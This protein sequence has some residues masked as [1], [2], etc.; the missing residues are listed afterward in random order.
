VKVLLHIPIIVILLIVSGH[1]ESLNRFSI[2]GYYKSFF[3]VYDQPEYRLMD[4]WIDSPEIG[5]VSNRV[6]LDF[7]CNLY[8]RLNFNAAYSLAP[9][10]QDNSLFYS[11]LLVEDT[12]RFGYRV[13]D[14]D[15]RLYPGE[16]D[17]VGSFAIFHNLDR[18]YVD[19][20]ASDFDLYVGRQAIAWGS[21]RVINPADILVPY[22]FE[23]LDT[24]ERIGVDAIRIRVPLGTLSEFDAGAVMGEDLELESSAAFLRGKFYALKADISGML[25][26]FRENLL[27]GFDLATSWEGAGIWLETAYVWAGAFKEE[28]DTA[29]DKNYLRSSLGCDYS[30]GDKT[31][32][33]LEYSYNQAGSG[34]VDDYADLFQETAYADGSVYFFGEH[35]LIPGV[36]YQVTPLLAYNGQILTNLNDPSAFI[37]SMLEYSYA[38][39]VY[40][41]AGAFIGLGKK[42]ELMAQPGT[43]IRL[44]SEFGTYPDIYFTLFSIYF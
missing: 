35:Y 20:R 25:I 1:G 3:V 23:E 9:R 4:R 34:D 24:E 18:F 5:A 36:I 44:N 30:F 42:P 40:L 29:R 41:S 14:F 10:I 26:G 2:G 16:G 11:N 22:R 7:S 6:R 12:D 43:E 8:E 27:A 17:F 13:I 31:Y 28:S 37:Y 15:S 21:A 38:E 33:F 39:N 32:G 19:L